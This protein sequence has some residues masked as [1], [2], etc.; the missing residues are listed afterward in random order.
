MITST[1]FNSNVSTSCSEVAEPPSAAPS[2]SWNKGVVSD[3]VSFGDS[4]AEIK[5]CLMLFANVSADVFEV[6]FRA[7]VAWCTWISLK[8][9]KMLNS[10]DAVCVFV[11]HKWWWNGFD[12]NVRGNPWSMSTVVNSHWS[13]QRMAAVWEEAAIRKGGGNVA[14]AGDR[15][16]EMVVIN[17][18]CLAQ[19]SYFLSRQCYKVKQ[20]DS[21]PK[22]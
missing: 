20:S 9:I 22:C 3:H 12:A 18:L 19:R 7:A 16:A 4:A 1:E 8:D 21:N 13:R 15:W 11:K 10:R 17:F 14:I 6:N 5:L 2:G